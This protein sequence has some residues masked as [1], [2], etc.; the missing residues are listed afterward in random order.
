LKS[1]TVCCPPTIFS[2]KYTIGSYPPL[3]LAEARKQARLV[4]ELVARGID[5]AAQKKARRRD[6]ASGRNRVDTLVGDFIDRHVSK[7]RSHKE[8]ERILEHDVLPYWSSRQVQEIGRRDVI[9]LLD[10]VEDRGAGH[11]AVYASRIVS[12]FFAFLV[13]RDI[14]AANSCAGLKPRRG[15]VRRD[16]ILSD[17]EMRIFW[18]AAI[19]LCFPFGPLFQLLLLTG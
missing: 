4:L 2:R 8:V 5:P 19:A 15:M 6:I 12:K 3:D 16:R 14:I 13:E 7:L 17:E 11:M 9:E 1:P 18:Q 10:R